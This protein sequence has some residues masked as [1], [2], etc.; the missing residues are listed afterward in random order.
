MFAYGGEPSTIDLSGCS[1]ERNI[2]VISGA[3]GAGKTSLLNAIK[4]L[5]LGLNNEELRRV[6]L[7]G[8]PLTPKQYVNGVSGRWY[9]V[10]N[11]TAGLADTAKVAL[12]WFDGD[13]RRVQAVDCR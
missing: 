2:V 5:F 4:L 9:G 13:G 12:S 8:S 11:N 10:F 1:E 7:A 3:N 6:G